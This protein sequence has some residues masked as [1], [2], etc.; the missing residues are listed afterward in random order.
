MKLIPKRLIPAA[1][2]ALVVL[3]L[4][5]ALVSKNAGSRRGNGAS[6]RATKEVEAYPTPS[7]E[8][9]RAYYESYGEV[10]GT[11]PVKKTKALKTE[12]EALALLKE[13]GFDQFGVS[14][15]FVVEGVGQWDAEASED[16][17]TKHPTYE[18]E[19]LA[20][21]YTLWRV[22]LNGDCLT[23]TSSAI[24][25]RAGGSVIY[26]ETEHLLSYDAYTESFYEVA[27]NASAQE[28]RVVERI[29]AALLEAVTAG[30][31]GVQ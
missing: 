1:A 9:I 11:T 23:A 26:S 20:E 17:K 29:D 18:T 28:L 10:V 5:V 16:S 2:A 27:P 6:S 22:Y 3:V 15:P 21:D 8:E 14:C 7:P 25:A 30:E 12:A 13:R 4:V 24:N 31:E 19:Y